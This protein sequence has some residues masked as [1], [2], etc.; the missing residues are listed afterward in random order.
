[1]GPSILQGPH[2]SAHRSTTT[3]RTF[4]SS[5]TC[6]SKV[7]S[8]TSITF[9]CPLIGI[10]SRFEGTQ[11]GSRSSLPGEP[12]DGGE[13]LLHLLV[14][15]TL[16]DAVADTAANVLVQELDADGSQR[17]RRGGDLGKDVGAV[18]ILINHA[19]QPAHLAF[20][21]PESGLQL[22]LT[23][24]VRV[25][26]SVSIPPGGICRIPSEVDTKAVRTTLGARL[27][28]QMKLVAPSRLLLRAARS[29][30]A[31]SSPE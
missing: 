3:G 25:V 30:A 13:E 4:D 19:L 15:R 20:D 16:L 23:T 2:Q 10:S 29:R 8:V 22:P 11:F 12:G 21:P 6:C 26:H 27:R 24:C 14:A 17:C 5:T 18:P 1:M 28:H 31:R 9:V 7:A